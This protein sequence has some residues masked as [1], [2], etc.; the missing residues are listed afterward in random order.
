VFDLLMGVIGTSC[1]LCNLPLNHDHYVPSASLGML[2]IYRSSSPG[3]GHDWE[4][5]ERVVPFTAEHA[6]L[7][8]AVAVLHD[9]RVVAG[10]VEDGALEADGESHFVD[11]ADEGYAYHRWCHELLGG[12]V[13]TSI[14]THAWAQVQTYAGQLFEYQD[15]IAHGKAWMLVDPRTDS[16]DGRRSRARIDA[17]REQARL[18]MPRRNTPTVAE[19]LASDRGWRGSMLR[20]DHA[21]RHILRYRDNV[22]PELDCAAYPALVWAMKEYGEGMPDPATLAEVEA[23][24]VALKAAVE[25]DAAAILIMTTIGDGQAQ[26]IIQA[27]DEAATVAAITA[28]PSGSHAKPVD[29]DNEAD[30]AWKVYFTTMSPRARR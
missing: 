5:G 27:R 6:W 30:P 21:P 22:H 11:D 10:R 12:E 8:D 18:R 29:F 7:C 17:I 23:Y 26:F 28:L 2:K 15:L 19:L 14:A 13:A 1:Q 25:R 4:P 9:G 16:D 20:T 24:E 3:G